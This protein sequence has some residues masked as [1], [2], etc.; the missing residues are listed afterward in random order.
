MILARALGILILAGGSAV[1]ADTPSTH[2][3]QA[4]AETPPSTR[5]S[6]E[7]KTSA[8]AAGQTRFSQQM[9]KRTLLRF[10]MPGRNATAGVRPPTPEEWNE[11]MDFL[12][13][14][15]PSRFS[16]LSS[17]NLP[18]NHP[19]RLD[20]I[21]KW[22]NYTFTRDHFPQVADEMA[23]RFHLED[24]L[25]ALT[26]AAQE[27]PDDIDEYKDKIHDKVASL[28]QLDFEERQTRI[29]KLE[30]LL[31]QQKA[32]LAADEKQQD[33][34]IDARTNSIINRLEKMNNRNLL[35]STA[36]TTRPDVQE[37][38]AV[39]TVAP[40]APHDPAVNAYGSPTGGNQK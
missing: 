33:K 13:V 8:G 4:T 37:D 11:M 17:L 28:V 29:D 25:F 16:V 1:W 6:Q 30:S 19:I 2:P 12:R 20:I 14:N 32:A 15:S 5:P 18:P 35:S 10:F 7:G 39:K 34:T 40:T 36:T 31:N 26:L 21:R 24:D 22:R 9:M 23:K 38:A 3:S 27:D